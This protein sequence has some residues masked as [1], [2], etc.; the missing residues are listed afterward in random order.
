MYKFRTLIVTCLASI[1][2][3]GCSSYFYSQVPEPFTSNFQTQDIDNQHFSKKLQKIVDKKFPNADLKIVADHFDV[4]IAGQVESQKTKE[5]VV[6]VIKKQK[7][8][9]DVYDYTTITVK[10]DYNGSSL[11]ESDVSDRLNEEQDIDS[12]RIKVVYV[13]SVVYLMGN[14]VGDLTHLNRAIRGIYAISGVKKV[15]NL[16]KEGHSDY[17]SGR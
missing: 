15:V 12:T 14:N 3:T 11:M 7:Y 16:I 6:Q 17:Y 9:R 13:D 10:P 1:F 4:L 2:F 5:E 8:A